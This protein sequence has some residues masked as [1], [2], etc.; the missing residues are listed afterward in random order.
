MTR[1]GLL[2]LVVLVSAAPARALDPLLFEGATPTSSWGFSYDQSV[3]RRIAANPFT[4]TTGEGRYEITGLRW[5]GVYTAIGGP[6]LLP[7]EPLPQDFALVVWEDAGGVPSGDPL[8]GSFSTFGIAARLLPQVVPVGSFGPR[9]QQA[10]Y[11]VELDEPILLDDGVTYWLSI[12]GTNPTGERRWAWVEGNGG[13][14]ALNG[15]PYTEWT[16]AS[17]LGINRSKA[18]ELYGTAF[19]AVDTATGSFG[20]VKALFD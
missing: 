7:Y 17:S 9:G 16:L 19:G 10:E 8:T 1:A 15:G 13:D 2:A 3:G 6:T 11:V 14:H 5:I 20:A 12:V 18:F 4:V